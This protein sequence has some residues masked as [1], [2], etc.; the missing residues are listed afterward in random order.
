V[1]A[2][3]FRAPAV[4]FRW[5]GGWLFGH[6]LLLVR[7]RGR[8]SARRYDTVLE[9]VRFDPATSEAVVVAGFGPDSDWLLNL[10]ANGEAEIAIGRQRFKAVH[11]IVP[12]DEAMAIM[13]DYERRNRL[14]APVARFLLSRLLGWRYTSSPADR[15]RLVRQLPMVAFR[16]AP[17]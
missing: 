5:Q 2:A 1:L 9:V 3:L 15:R 13:A 17:G 12:E 16:P 6:R 10:Q 14:I 11:R 8:K 4:A 7:H